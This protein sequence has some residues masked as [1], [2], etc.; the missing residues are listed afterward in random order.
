MGEFTALSEILIVEKNKVTNFESYVAGSF[1]S[2]VG[3]SYAGFRKFVECQVFAVDEEF[4]ELVNF[5]VGGAN[6]SR[7]DPWLLTVDDLER[8]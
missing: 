1:V 6:G 4:A 5:G 2:V 7:K 8:R 3:L